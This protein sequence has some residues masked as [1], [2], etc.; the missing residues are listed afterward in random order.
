M[1]EKR[2]FAK[3]I[4]DS[5]AFLDM[6]QSSQCLYFHLSMRA[7]D[8]GFVNNPKKIQRMVGASED[9]LKI[10]IAKNFIIP[11]DSGIVVIKH[12]YIHNYIRA[13]RLV[14]TKYQ[15]ERAQLVLK[16]NNAYTLAAPCQADVRQMS[17]RCQADDGIDKNRL[18]KSRLDKNRLDKNNNRFDEFWSEYPKKVE[19]KKA[20]AVFNK[21]NPDDDLFSTM[22]E[23]I[24]KQKQSDQ[25]QRG[26]VPNPTTWLNGERWN[27]DIPQAPQA[28]PT[29]KYGDYLQREPVKN[30]RFGMEYLLERDDDE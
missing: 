26:F 23:A 15:D 7:D 16:E 24:K 10:L 30:E 5:D 18:D 29:K 19:K 28:S 3:T 1:A 14:K 25:W 8:E 22:I 11:F 27:D 9:D 17:G 2:M 20:M 12:W 6:P 13:D 4:I 21:I